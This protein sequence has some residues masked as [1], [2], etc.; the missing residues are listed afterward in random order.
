MGSGGGDLSGFLSRIPRGGPNRSRRHLRECNSDLPTG[1]RM[2]RVVWRVTIL[3]V[4]VT[5]DL[6]FADIVNHLC[7]LDVLE[8]EVRTGLIQTPLTLGPSVISA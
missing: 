7:V 3:V 6:D 8:D 4:P 2:S 1:N 5:W